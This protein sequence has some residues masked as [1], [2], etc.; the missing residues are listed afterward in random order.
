LRN[1]SSEI[2]ARENV[3]LLAYSPMGFGVLSG[4]FL[5]GENHQSAV[6][7]VSSIRDIVV[8]NR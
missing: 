5:T 7:F 4:K 8:S 1:A 6:K 3:S 2:C